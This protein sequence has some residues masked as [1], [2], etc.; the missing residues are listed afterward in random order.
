MKKIILIFFISLSFIFGFDI[1]NVY[2]VI[3][4]KKVN[5]AF[6]PIKQ[7]SWF[8]IKNDLWITNYHVINNSDI[9]LICNTK[10]YK[11]EPKC[12]KIGIVI[13]TDKNND[14]A[15]FKILNFNKKDKISFGDD[16]NL[17]EKIK[18]YWYPVIGWN[19]ITVT[20]GIISGYDNWL[21]KTDAVIDKWM[22]WWP[23]L[24]K[25]DKII[26]IVDA[27]KIDNNVL[28][29]FIWKEKIL[30][31]I[32]N[33]NNLNYKINV[34][35]IKD[36]INFIK[37]NEIKANFN[38]LWPV[39]INN[40]DKIKFNNKKIHNLG[41]IKSL[42]L[43]D[44]NKEFN[45]TVFFWQYDWKYI[46][47]V[48]QDIYKFFG[49][50][51]QPIITKNKYSL[52]F[53]KNNDDKIIGID[54]LIKLKDYYTLKVLYYNF[55]WLTN[56]DIKNLIEL[57]KKIVSIKNI[58]Q[59]KPNEIKFNNISFKN[60]LNFIFLDADKLLLNLKNY[61]FGI[62]LECQDYKSIKTIK[63]KGYKI[64]ILNNS[65][66]KIQKNNNDY[67]CITMLDKISLTDA[68]KIILESL[69]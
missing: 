17:N 52:S 49:L 66:L 2:K 56:K 20:N 42:D 58:N 57:F 21:Y 62:D 8:W 31:F 30:P 41:F 22:S 26:W 59:N 68:L 40:L 39:Y 19:T 61:N 27:I 44:N 48:I 18:I 47:M 3:V 67:L 37:Q 55:L 69:K 54:L 16:I 36:F 29:Y 60:P 43:L 65:R 23:V 25:N 14:L 35:L 10:N 9:L 6:K 63:Y 5:N 7:G 46:Q 13:K 45:I 24:D 64:S 33:I 12:E 4:Y 50:K 51:Y 38:L 34:R 11:D 28:W 53:I 32:K 1:S 15:L